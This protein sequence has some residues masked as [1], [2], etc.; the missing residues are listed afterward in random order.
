MG[1][2]SKN[3][4]LPIGNLTSQIF[5]NIYLNELDQFIKHELKV[6]H[7]FR[8]A[9]DFIMVNDDPIKLDALIPK[10]QNFLNDNLSLE[11]HPNKIIQC[12]LS[13]GIDFLG[14]VVLP[15]HIVLRTSTKH[16]IFKK[17]FFKQNEVLRGELNEDSFKQSVQSYL[18][19]LKHCDGFSISNNLRN[20]FN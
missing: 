11:L 5:A 7:Y 17:L 1:I 14:Y 8:Y 9:D 19:A 12:K 16:R 6:R 15:Y 20:N 4:G 3:I 13:Q 10:V 2:Q 18:G